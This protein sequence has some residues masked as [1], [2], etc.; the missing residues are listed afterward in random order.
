[1]AR[2][3]S[4][5]QQA[6]LD[7][8]VRFRGERTY[9]PSTREIGKA[10]RIASSSV[11]QHLAAL[12]RKGAIRRSPGRARSI[13]LVGVDSGIG[14]AQVPVIGR[15]AAGRPLLTE[16]SV[17]GYLSFP[18]VNGGR[19]YALR[20]IG[21]SMVGAGIL[22]GDFVICRHQEVGEDGDIVV[23]LVENEA[24]VKRLKRSGKGWVLRPENDA[25]EPIP[26]RGE[27][28][29]QGRVVAVHRV[30]GRAR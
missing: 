14:S 17:E 23:A 3:L 1:M 22:P 2:N 19:L 30:I 29:I 21:D 9:S 26:V 20:V 24:T 6:L 28:R 13:E 15:V 8:I 25:Y 5:R 7:F 4:N 12:E 27:V 10:F 11:H 18:Q 16:S